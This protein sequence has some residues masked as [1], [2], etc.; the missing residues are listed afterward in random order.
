MGWPGLCCFIAVSLPKGFKQELVTIQS[1]LK[2]KKFIANWAPPENFHLTLKFLG[3]VSQKKIPFIKRA[4]NTAVKEQLPFEL[5][6]GRL[7]AFPRLARPK[8]LWAGIE[9]DSKVLEPLYHSLTAELD[10]QGVTTGREKF[11]PHVTLARIKAPVHPGLVKEILS[12]DIPFF[13]PRFS[14]Q[15]ID[16]YNSRLTRS[17]AVHTPLFSTQKR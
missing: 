4:M 7:G 8:V 17:G 15:T 13:S 16:L 6:L 11:V 2:S 3:D 12:Q 5:A 14:V 1:H 10:K 9:D